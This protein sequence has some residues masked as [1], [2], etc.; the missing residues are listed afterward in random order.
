MA[1]ANLQSRHPPRSVDPSEPGLRAQSISLA[2]GAVR[3]KDRG[4][5][6]LPRLGP[7]ALNGS[8]A[9]VARRRFAAPGEAVD[10][11]PAVDVRYM[12]AFDREHLPRH[13]T[14]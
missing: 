8:M 14:L 5:P 6:R 2:S 9:E 1:E 12:A 7:E 4:T 13:Q 3:R 10:L 11:Q